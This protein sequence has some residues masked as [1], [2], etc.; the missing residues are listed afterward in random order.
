[1]AG[2]TVPVASGVE[3]IIV[4]IWVIICDG[5]GIDEEWKAVRD[6][7]LIVMSVVISDAGG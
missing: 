1:M 7:K 4:G 5:E 6:E 3:E 2:E